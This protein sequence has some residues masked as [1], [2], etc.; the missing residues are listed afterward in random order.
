MH[1]R[2]SWQQTQISGSHNTVSAPQ[3]K[4]NGRSDLS[5]FIIETEVLFTHLACTCCPV[6]NTI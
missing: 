4:L 1:I 5:D 2:V 3:E 6:S